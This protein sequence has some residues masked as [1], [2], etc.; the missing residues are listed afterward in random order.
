MD[1]NLKKFH[2]L[3]PLGGG[4]ESEFRLPSHRTLFGTPQW[5]SDPFGQLAGELVRCG[6]GRKAMRF[7]AWKHA[8]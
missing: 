7:T 1:G 6:F 8:G 2:R 3:P 4:C 5:G